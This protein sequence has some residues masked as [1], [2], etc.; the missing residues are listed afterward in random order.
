MF[1]QS[2][3]MHYD[4]PVGECSQKNHIRIKYSWGAIEYGCM[5]SCMNHAHFPTQVIDHYTLRNSHTY[6]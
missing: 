5:L 1:T 2:L 3:H 6:I 4:F